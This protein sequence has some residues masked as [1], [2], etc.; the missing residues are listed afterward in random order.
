MTNWAINY[1]LQK[2]DWV[3]DKFR[4]FNKFKWLSYEISFLKKLIACVMEFHFETTD[5][6]FNGTPFVNSRL[7]MEFLFETTDLLFDGTPLWTADF[8]FQVLFF[9]R[10]TVRWNSQIK[11]TDRL[12][13]VIPKSKQLS[14]GITFIISRLTVWWN[15]FFKKTQLCVQWNLFWKHLTA[16]VQEFVFKTT[17]W[18][19]DGIPVWTADF[20]F[21]G[22][23]LK[24]KRLTVRWN[25]LSKR[26]DL[27]C[28]GIPFWK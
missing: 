19:C 22:F 8:L 5:W 13:N 6:L 12:S 20:L 7:P 10:L 18:L 4:F 15:C 1:F 16:S 28:D 23:T 21:D 24:K 27:L 9:L 17:N 11:T 26:I 2:T 3:C 14:D 25:S